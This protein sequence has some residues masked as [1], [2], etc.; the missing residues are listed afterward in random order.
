MTTPHEIERIGAHRRSARDS[1]GLP[2]EPWGWGPKRKPETPWRGTVGVWDGY[3][4][5]QHPGEVNG[6]QKALSWRSEYTVMFAVSLPQV[7][8]GQ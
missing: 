5:R 3:A 1:P 4:D 7:G 2:A 6:E 8:Q